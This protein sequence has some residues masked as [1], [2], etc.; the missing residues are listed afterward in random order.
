LTTG[1]SGIKQLMRKRCGV[2]L[3]SFICFN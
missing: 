3:C 1:D 2:F